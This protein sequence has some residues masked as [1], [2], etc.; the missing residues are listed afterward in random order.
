MDASRVSH[1]AMV[2]DQDRATT[3]Y[4]HISSLV[5][6]RSKNGVWFCRKISETQVAQLIRM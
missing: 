4:I 5:T 3:F 2:F 1:P 6:I